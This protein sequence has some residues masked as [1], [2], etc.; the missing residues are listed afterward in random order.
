MSITFITDSIG[1]TIIATAI[2][3]YYDVHTKHKRPSIK[4]IKPP[5][6]HP[7]KDGAI[8]VLHRTHIIGDQLLLHGSSDSRNLI[9]GTFDLN[10]KQMLPIENKIKKYVLK[11]GHAVKCSITLSYY[12]NAMIPFELRMK[13]TDTTDKKPLNVTTIFYNRQSGYRFDYATGMCEKCS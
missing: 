12:D 5:G 6:Y 8:Y 3:N 10:I 2:I 11:T 4:H 13:A 1:R 7:V 9:T